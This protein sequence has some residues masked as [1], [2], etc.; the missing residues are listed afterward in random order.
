MMDS[1]RSLSGG[2]RTVLLTEYVWE[3]WKEGDP[4]VASGPE[5]FFYH[6]PLRD[7]K[8][9]VGLAGGS[10]VTPFR[11]MIKDIIDDDLDMQM[12][13][14]YGTRCPDDI[15]F[16]EEL[17][18]LTSQAPE[19]ISAHI[20]CSEPDDSWQG[21]SGFLTNESIQNIVGDIRSKSFFISGPAAMVSLPGKG[22]QGLRFA[23]KIDP[24]GSFW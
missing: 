21:A 3:N 2:C 15:I 19:R 1:T 7:C 22:T 20:F 11:S 5:G 24:L 10:G 23:K 6:E 4:I 17:M 18:Q 16:G 9:V 12:T 8:H 13:L 14:L